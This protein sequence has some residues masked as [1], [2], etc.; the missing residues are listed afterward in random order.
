MPTAAEL[1]ARD[2]ISTRTAQR[3]I[4]TACQRLNTTEEGQDRAG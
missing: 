1:A 3:R 4:T 2:G